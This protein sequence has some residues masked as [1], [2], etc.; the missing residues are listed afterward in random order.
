VIAFKFLGVGSVGLFSGFAW[1]TPDGDRPGDWIEAPAPLERCRRGIHAARL[2]HLTTWIDDE[3]WTIELGGLV[4]EHGSTLVAQRGRLLRR[5][6]PWCAAAAAAF[7]DACAF[8]ARDQAVRTL[9]LRGGTAEAA[10]LASA[11]GL[12]AAGA[13]AARL[14]G[15]L[16]G[17]GA[18]ACAFAADAVALA[19]GRRPESWAPHPGGA[20]QPRQTP[21]ATAANLGFVTAHSGGV[22]RADADGDGA[23]D[24]GFAAERAWQLDWLV[25][26]L[27]LPRP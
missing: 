14:A 4:E 6:E 27:S 13:V 5:I 16:G 21:G 8:R 7:A 24:A 1:P 19:D 17:A 9:E 26:Q 10:E 2:E 18:R 20:R 25:E 23:Y 12:P 15:T 11:A 22:E 3:L